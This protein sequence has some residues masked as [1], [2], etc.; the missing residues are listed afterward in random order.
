MSPAPGGRGFD[1]AMDDALAT[2]APRRDDS[3]S[4]PP[5]RAEPAR[6][7]DTADTKAAAPCRKAAN[8]SSVEP[9]KKADR[10]DDTEPK[11]ADR[12]DEPT[13]QNCAPA[14]G[15]AQPAEDAKTDANAAGQGD[16]SGDASDATVNAAVDTT[17]PVAAD[18]GDVA[19]AA[20]KD[21]AAPAEDPMARGRRWQGLGE[22][23]PGDA[24]KAARTGVP[25]GVAG[26]NGVPGVRA[27]QPNA[28]LQAAAAVAHGA[29]VAEMALEAAAN[30]QA[31]APVSAT[32]NSA[33]TAAVETAAA[34]PQT[35]SAADAMT[36]I[37]NAV[38][39]VAESVAAV[40]TSAGADAGAGDTH[41]QPQPKPQAPST[42]T[43]ASETVAVG[44]PSDGMRFTVN[45]A[46]GNAA[47]ANATPRH[48]EVVL[49]QIV[50]SIRLHA[51]QGTTEARVQLRPEHLGALNITLKVEQNQ[52]TATI[53]ADVAAVRAWIE[54]HE[55]SLRQ[56]LSE[57]GLHLAKLVVHPDDQQASKDEHD[58]ERPRRQSRRRSW[59]D[60]E[61]TFEV[62]V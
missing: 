40:E 41:E 13:G 15:P 53:Q 54:S 46:A 44:G 52:V 32:T 11:A 38:A 28:G 61:A 24:G 4:R 8:P 21:A 34:K 9:A 12:D 1:G 16:T 47:Y 35:A 25:R 5:R 51:V 31:E 26:G 37:E 3:P 42:Q 10:A 29:P 60:E 33:V 56:A 62:L 36:A 19:A 20:G 22:Q 55:S 39:N 59:R 49:P 48:E 30:P 50:Q 27:G 2:R 18:A 14:D 23:Q 58:G 45:S 57:Q 6:Q 17:V 7:R 43:N